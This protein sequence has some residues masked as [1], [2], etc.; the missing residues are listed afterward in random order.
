MA[1]RTRRLR[2]VIDDV[3]EEGLEE[4]LTRGQPLDD[5]HGGATAAGTA[6]SACA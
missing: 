4:E 3:C 2:G 1:K 5:A 6:T